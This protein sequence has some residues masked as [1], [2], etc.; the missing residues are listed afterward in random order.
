MMHSLLAIQQRPKIWGLFLS[1]VLAFVIASC[2]SETRQIKILEPVWNSALDTVFKTQKLITS[3]TNYSANKVQEM[4]DDKIYIAYLDTNT[5]QYLDSLTKLE[6]KEMMLCQILSGTYQRI[7]TGAEGYDLKFSM[8]RKSISE[9]KSMPNFST[10]EDSTYILSD[11]LKNIS[12]KYKL[13]ITQSHSMATNLYQAY[14]TRLED[15]IAEFNAKARAK[16][17]NS[18]K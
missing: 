2:S 17:A 9:G 10:F 8:R 16:N 14:K 15:E 12:A 5:Q 6:Q 4:I 13:S 11:S 18:A 3:R 7:V 1:A